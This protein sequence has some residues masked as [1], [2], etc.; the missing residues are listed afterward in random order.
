MRAEEHSY[1]MALF[2]KAAVIIS[3]FDGKFSN[4]RRKYRSSSKVTV[5]KNERLRDYI[6]IAQSTEYCT[7]NGQRGNVCLGIMGSLRKQARLMGQN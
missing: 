6:R 7:R 3:S 1:L 5:K 4:K 2:W